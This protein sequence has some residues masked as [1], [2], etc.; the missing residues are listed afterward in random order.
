MTTN[1]NVHSISEYPKPARQLKKSINQLKAVLEDDF[2]GEDFVAEARKAAKGFKSR[3]LFEFP[4]VLIDQ[5]WEK[6]VAILA[7][8]KDGYQIVFL[9]FR[10]KDTEI[11]VIEA[12]NAPQTL[13]SFAC[14]FANILTVLPTSE[15]QAIQ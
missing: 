11:S 15:T 14:S 6:A 3:F 5:D 12:K 2:N 8:T 13:V 4:V 1:T 9:L 10:Q 7:P